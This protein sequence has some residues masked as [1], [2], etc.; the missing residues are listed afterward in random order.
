[1]SDLSGGDVSKP[2]PSQSPSPSGKELGGRPPPKPSFGGVS[3][4]E[5]AGESAKQA[6]S[7]TPPNRLSVPLGE[8][9]TSSASSGSSSSSDSSSEESEKEGAGK[10]AGKRLAGG[11][12]GRLGNTK[13]GKGLNAL[14]GAKRFISSAKAGGLA[15]TAAKFAWSKVKGLAKGAAKKAIKQ[16]IKKGLMAC[17]ASMMCGVIVSAAALLL[18]AALAVGLVVVVVSGADQLSQIGQTEILTDEA[19]REQITIDL[20]TEELS[21]IVDL[22]VDVPTPVLLFPAELMELGGHADWRIVA[23]DTLASELERAAERAKELWPKWECESYSSTPA[24]STELSPETEPEPPPRPERVCI[25]VPPPLDEP[26]LLPISSEQGAC[27]FA[28]ALVPDAARLSLQRLEPA[29]SY[30]D[31]PLQALLDDPDRGLDW[32]ADAAASITLWN[33]TSDNVDAEPEG[34]TTDCL[35]MLDTEG[36]QRTVALGGEN[37]RQRSELILRL[38]QAMQTVPV[39]IWAK[40]DSGGGL[41]VCAHQPSG[42]IDR[43]READIDGFVLVRL[44]SSGGFEEANRVSHC[45]QV[46][47]CETDHSHDANWEHCRPPYEHEDETEEGVEDSELPPLQTW[48]TPDPESPPYPT[49]GQMAS[50]ARSGVAAATD[51][52]IPDLWVSAGAAI[53][54]GILELTDQQRVRLAQILLFKEQGDPSKPPPK[55]EIGAWQQRLSAEYGV[56]EADLQERWIGRVDSIGDPLGTCHWLPR[57]FLGNFCNGVIDK[58]SKDALAAIGVTRDA[59]P[60]HDCEV[61]APLAPG[62]K[63]PD[64]DKEDELQLVPLPQEWTP[65]DKDVWLAPCLLGTLEAILTA[66]AASMPDGP[67]FVSS[68]YRPYDHQASIRR[69]RGCEPETGSCPGVAPAGRSMHNT[70]LAIDFVDSTG[71][72]ID[73]GTPSFRWMQDRLPSAGL[74]NLKG[75]VP[76]GWHWSPNAR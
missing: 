2:K 24:L 74:L 6:K 33:N 13:L 48:V 44:H 66:S 7:G 62:A 46:P 68:G 4:S 65:G 27:A 18:L 64:L 5:A 73:V 50:R 9:G 10:R 55:V 15:K 16:G 63:F 32:C 35:V 58:A 57:L 1:M 28:H 30:A 20:Q 41:S 59:I 51:I 26:P 61:P 37:V 17:Y 23:T 71:T 49:F 72:L 76:E 8:G 39:G 40:P 3:G 47:L 56:S 67:L 42:T 70:G 14:G 53:D 25:F 60:A 45:P 22:D 29:D 34:C 36:E 54:L 21:A 52:D 31:R 75:S 12:M 11:L 43:V 38:T 69:E 19:R